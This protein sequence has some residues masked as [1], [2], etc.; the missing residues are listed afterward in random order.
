M[1]TGVRL[2]GSKGRMTGGKVPG[3]RLGMAAEAS[4]LTWVKA[5]LGSTS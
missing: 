4:E 3:G 1:H 2:V 5:P